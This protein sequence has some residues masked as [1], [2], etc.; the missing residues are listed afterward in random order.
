MRLS[1][2]ATTLVSCVFLTMFLCSCGGTS[3]S[4]TSTQK[5]NSSLTVPSG[6]GGDSSPTAPPKP[7]VTGTWGNIKGT[8]LWKKAPP[9]LP[10]LNVI[11]DQDHCLMKGPVPDDLYII[12]PTNQGLANVVLWIYDVS[13]PAKPKAPPVH[14]SLLAQTQGEVVM[15]QPCCRFEPRVVAFRLGQTLVAKNSSPVVHNFNWQ[16]FTGEGDNKAI[17]AGGKHEVVVKNASYRPFTVSCGVHPWMK[18][19]FWVFDHPYFARTDAEGRYEIKNAP[20][21][22]YNLVMWHEGIGWVNGNK[23]GEKVEIKAD[24]TIEIYRSVQGTE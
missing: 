17:P 11:K 21:G 16:G 3:T 2:S 7:A 6:K 23:L 13:D 14:P 22:T 24:E 9:A 15:D 1:L 10:P 18:A 5:T 20:A 19:S 8:V 12:N 4:N